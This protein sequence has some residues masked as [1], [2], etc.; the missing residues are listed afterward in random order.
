MSEQVWVFDFHL[1]TEGGKV[2]RYCSATARFGILFTP[3]HKL[4]PSS[5]TT[6]FILNTS[7]IKVL[8]NPGMPKSNM[9][10]FHAAGTVTY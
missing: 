10:S 2:H 9:P 4:Q 5:G 8:T 1:A 3:E 7:S 6:Y